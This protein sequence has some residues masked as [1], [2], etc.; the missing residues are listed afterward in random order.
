M[1]DIATSPR[2]LQSHLLNHKG[3]AKV[4]FDLGS[5]KKCTLGGSTA[6]VARAFVQLGYSGLLGRGFDRHMA[7]IVRTF[8]A[9]HGLPA[10]GEVDARTLQTLD[11][12]LVQQASIVEALVDV[13]AHEPHTSPAYAEA[14]SQWPDTVPVWGLLPTRRA[15]EQWV[16]FVAAHDDTNTRPYDDFDNLCTGFAAQVYARY[17]SRSRLGDAAI[18]RLQEVAVHAG[19]KLPKYRVPV[20]MVINRGHAFNAFLVDEH[21]PRNLGSYMIYEPQNDAFI[22][23]THPYW[24]LYIERFG[25]SICDLVDFENGRKYKFSKGNEFIVNGVGTMVRVSN[26][27]V[28]NLAKDFAIA[29]SGMMNYNH[30]VKIPGGLPAFLQYQAMQVWKLDDEDLLEVGKLW[31]GRPFRETVGGVPKPMTAARFAELV[32]RPALAPKLSQ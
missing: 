7:Q 20:F 18:G 30:Y 4:V 28:A 17:S 19:K 29:E 32:G 10:S 8:Q 6:T 3:L 13:L 12:A 5:L 1:P 31:M 16:R 22:N 26:T 27:R 21:K 24:Q 2:L 14:V 9:S 23:D 25:A 15:R 11:A